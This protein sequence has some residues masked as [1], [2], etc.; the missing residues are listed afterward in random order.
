LWLKW[1]DVWTQTAT[2]RTHNIEAGNPSGF[3]AGNR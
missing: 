1:G 3:A 2:E